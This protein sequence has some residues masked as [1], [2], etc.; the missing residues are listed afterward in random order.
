MSKADCLICIEVKACLAA[1]AVTA[2]L[3]AIREL[4][5]W[6]VTCGFLNG[7]EYQAA[8]LAKLDSM[9]GEK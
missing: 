8:L 7:A 6:A 5:K 2:R 1:K 4:K 3:A 9:E